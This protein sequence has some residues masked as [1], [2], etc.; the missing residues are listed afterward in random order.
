[1][2]AREAGYG[3]TGGTRKSS[4]ATIT[5]FFASASFAAFPF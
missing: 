5:P 4:A 1:M 2:S 3:A